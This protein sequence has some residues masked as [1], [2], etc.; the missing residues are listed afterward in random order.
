MLAPSHPCEDLIVELIPKD[1]ATVFEF[2]RNNGE[3]VDL[4]SREYSKNN[5]VWRN[6]TGRFIVKLDSE[7]A[8]KKY[9]V[10]TTA[11]VANK[12]ALG[13]VDEEW[14]MCDNRAKSESLPSDNGNETTLADE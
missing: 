13:D 4:G 9:K 11:D 10:F 2:I 5:V 12:F 1:L 8:S 3:G 14:E 6:G 7:D